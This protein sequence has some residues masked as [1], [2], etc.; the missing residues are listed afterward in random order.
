MRIVYTSARYI[1]SVAK[2]IWSAVIV[3]IL[4]GV[5]INLFSGS[6]ENLFGSVFIAI[7]D[8]FNPPLHAPQI[9][10]IVLIVL[11]IITTLASALLYVLLRK[12]Y[13]DKPPSLSPEIQ[14]ILDYLKQD[15]EERK[16]KEIAQKQR[17]DLALTHY[18]RSIRE[19]N[20]S[21]TPQGFA[22]HSAHAPALIFA[23]VPLESAF[24]P[25]QAISDRPIFDAPYEQLRLLGA[26]RERADLSEETRTAYIQGLHAT[27][28]SQLGVQ[29]NQQ[30]T[31]QVLPIDEVLRRLTPQH[32][33][34]IILGEPGS[35]KSTLLRWLALHMA[36]ASLSP[37]HPIPD[38][39][40]PVQVPVQ[41]RLHD[42]AAGLDKDAQ[43][44]KQFVV[45]QASQVHP[46]APVKLLDELARGRCLVLF[47][48]LDEVANAGTRRAVTDAVS[49]FIAEYTGVGSET[50]QYNRF[51]VTSRIVGYEPRALARYA[52]YTLLELNDQQIG[53]LLLN[54]YTAIECYLAMSARGMQDLVEEERTAAHKA[55]AQL[56]DQCVRMLQSSPGLRQL[57]SN[58]L[59][60]TMMAILQASGRT[61]PAHRLELCQMLTRTLLDTWNQE[62]GRAMFSA[63][64]LPLAELLLSTFAYRLH[65]HAPALSASEVIAITRQ[66]MAEYHGRQAQEITEDT[67]LRF[68]ETLRSSSG[69]FVEVGEQLFCFANSTFQG[70][71]VARY[72]LRKP[73]EEL[74]QFALEHSQQ[75][76]WREPLLLL[77]ADKS[78]ESAGKSEVG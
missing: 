19:E 6:K 17:D 71:F 53:Q 63:G 55:G 25:F 77:N 52:H 4:V 33:V 50:H 41:I 36:T 24:V 73:R 70:Y 47:D 49:A 12:R 10:T 69:L 42:Y 62:S 31:R 30:R 78:V 13:P 51:L 20:Q 23:D 76:V 15:T 39:F 44:L 58:P 56:R 60:L 22:L 72:L 28:H 32:P 64:E 48:G 1:W 34:A 2:W 9:L 59:A 61:L 5:A 40:L 67:I 27:W 14:A 66:T 16:E 65:T 18:L 29:G 46:N 57:A 37:N 43:T 26:L 68:I 74:E 75:D 21:L 11:L 7:K 38:G 3:V 8:W 35:G 45:A 54:W